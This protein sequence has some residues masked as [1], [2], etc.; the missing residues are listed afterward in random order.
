VGVWQFR[1]ITHRHLLFRF[2]RPSEI[3][4]RR[5]PK[6]ESVGENEFTDLT[7]RDEIRRS[8][9]PQQLGK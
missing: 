1:Q 2:L 3:I 9:V 8:N 7:L 6:A 4:G 5:Y